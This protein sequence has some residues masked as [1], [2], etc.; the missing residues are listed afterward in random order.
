MK[1]TLLTLAC[2]A[3]GLP[4]LA[5]DTALLIPPKDG[6]PLA[7]PMAAADIAPPPFSLPT[8]RGVNPAYVAGLPGLHQGLETF[9]DF[10]RRS[11]KHD[12]V[13]IRQ[14]RV[15][16]GEVVIPPGG[17][18]YLEDSWGGE[19]ALRGEKVPILGRT[20]TYIDYDMT[21]VMQKDVTIPAGKAVA[22]GGTV[23]HYYASIGHEQMVNHTLHVRTISGLDWE[24]AFGSP[25]FSATEPN[26]WGNS[27]AQLYNQGKVREMGR[28]ALVFD[29][30]AGV[31]MDR[32]TYA[33]TEVF[34]GL[35]A[36]GDSWAMGAQTLRVAAVDEGAGTATVEL[37][38]GGAVVASK[39]LGP[40]LP[41]RLIEDHDAR[42]ALVFSH[43]DVVAFLSPW[44]KG[45]EDGKVSLKVYDDAFS[46]DY[47]TDF[48]RD[49]RFAVWPVTCPTGHA[50]GFM[51]T[52]KQEIRL[53]PGQSAE[54][55]EGYFRIVVNAVE[56]DHVTSWHIEDR[57]G[58]R[59]ADLGGPQ[60]ANVDL[61][62]G[63]GR[64]T[65]QSIH[66]DLGRALLARSYGTQVALETLA[67]AGGGVAPAPMA[68]AV[69]PA[70][71]P[72]ALLLALAVA[73]LAAGAVGYELAR[74]RHG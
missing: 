6:W 31:R 9:D 35:A 15:E 14:S 56:G 4:A 43:G 29:W 12:S 26:W 59:S 25:A 16:N 36:P 1:R 41:D 69:V 34:K 2:I 65:G 22:V 20:A 63:Q 55:P 68:A 50:F 73:V 3:L 60:I 70:G 38:E 8:E 10:M 17:L 21:V 18:A 72:P 33:E 11:L 61:V 67:K 46:F 74:R 40:V 48:A 39:V 42:K 23:Y 45:F 53:K 13:L 47:G 57:Q 62:L 71:T 64:V 52:N 54:G 30:L 7:N 24:W 27:F 5:N 66:K 28:E 44:P 32:M 37:V 58:N 51:L 49:P 19:V